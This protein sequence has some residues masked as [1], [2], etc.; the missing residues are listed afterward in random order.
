VR[1]GLPVLLLFWAAAAP[2]QVQPNRTTAYLPPT[3][4]TDARAVWVNPAGLGRVAEASVHFDLTVGDP[5]SSG[6]LRQLTVGF[7]SRG[8]AFGYQ[9]DVFAGG[10]RGHTYRFG[11]ASGHKRLSAGLA[12]AW[13]RGGAS[14]TGWDVGAAYDLAAGLSVGGVIANIGRPVT[15][16]VLQPV[17]YVPSATVRLFGPVAAFSAY[18]RFTSGDVLGYAFGGRVGLREGTK[19]PI[20]LIARLDADRSMRRAGFAFGVSVGADDLVGTVATM[21]GDANRLDAIS[22]YGVSARRLTR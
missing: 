20:R 14:Q 8:F 11:L 2:A 22:L 7:N 1:A 10:V 3:D 19:R 12:A 18:G 17:T 13:Y 15:R 6:R 16:G 9:R 4:V 21:P 5:G